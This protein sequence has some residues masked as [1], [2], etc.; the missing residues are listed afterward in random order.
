METFKKSISLNCIGGGAVLSGPAVYTLL[1][2]MAIVIVLGIYF[3]WK[4]RKSLKSFIITLLIFIVLVPLIYNIS[5]FL[6]SLTPWVIYT[7]CGG[8]TYPII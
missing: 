2:I 1:L 5:N 6:L 8:S 3:L 4:S 7:N